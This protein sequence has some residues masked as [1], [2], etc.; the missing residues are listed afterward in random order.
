MHL[1]IFNSIPLYFSLLLWASLNVTGGRTRVATF[2]VQP[3]EFPDILLGNN[4]GF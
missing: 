4:S 1:R 3:I 2:T